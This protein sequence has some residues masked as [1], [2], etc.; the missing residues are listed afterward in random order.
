MASKP[1]E[2]PL[3]IWAPPGSPLRVE[4]SGGVMEEIRARAVNGFYKVRGGVDVAGL[5]LGDVRPD[6]VRILDHL[7]FEI[8]YAHGPAFALSPRDLALVRKLIEEISN[9]GLEASGPDGARRVLG[10]CIS[11][12]RSDLAL[13]AGEIQIFDQLFPHAWQTILLLKPS[14]ATETAAAFFVR[15]PDGGMRTNR[16]YGE[17]GVAPM[18]GERR[19]RPAYQEA[20]SLRALAEAARHGSGVES[21]AQDVPAREP[22]ARESLAQP[23]SPPL[24]PEMSEED[25][26]ARRAVPEKPSASHPEP[27]FRDAAG[28]T[29]STAPDGLADAQPAPPLEPAAIE[30]RD[31]ER[32]ALPRPLAALTVK[33]DALADPETP[34]PATGVPE[35]H[36]EELP[37]GGVRATSWLR[38]AMPS[39]ALILLLVLGYLVYHA[40]NGAPPSVVFFRRAAGDSQEIVWRVQGM[41][42]ARSAVITIKNGDETRT[43]DLIRTGQLSGVYRDSSLTAASAVTMDIER[44]TGEKIHREAPPLDA[45]SVVPYLG[46]FSTPEPEASSTPE[47]PAAAA[48]GESGDPRPILA[49]PVEAD[50][51]PL[52]A[53]PSVPVSPPVASVAS[54]A[55]PVPSV[56]SP[57][58]S[59]GERAAG[60]ATPRLAPESPV[61]TRVTEAPSAA[62]PESLAPSVT[63]P[64]P[65]LDSGSRPPANPPSASNAA[66]VPP[67]HAAA[68]A[69]GNSGAGQVPVSQPPVSPPPVPRPLAPP[70][71][72]VQQPAAAKA[73]P[74][75]V[76]AGRVIWTGQLR[77]NQSLQIDGKAATLGVMSAALP[78]LPVRVNVLPGELTPQGLIVYTA[79]PRYRNVGNAVEPP[80]PTNGWNQTHYRYDP[81]RAQ[82]LIVTG[83]PS[84]A[85]GWRRV[86]V[87]NEDKNTSVIVIDWQADEP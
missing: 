69:A 51:L 80:G 2:S 70:A 59:A 28:D 18:M 86:T 35:W 47:A 8:E 60:G 63:Q 40:L 72:A 26:L 46:G 1:V 7:P 24:Q 71:P 83:P 19:A 6:S 11:H 3:F 42:D 45:D 39:V 56:P 85:N 44:S 34:E 50:P 10:L 5:L 84:E 81:V 9:A 14:H 30:P 36:E 55:P 67:P 52:E 66:N 38:W 43:I 78:G 48:G 76:A 25:I 87:R 22:A 27:P 32:L 61:Q 57:V 17:F 12:A 54:S 64:G 49:T 23:E 74:A 13:S 33:E 37:P 41:G 75:R 20:S 58:E 77:K 68:P 62:R 16:S 31:I 65:A 21:P 79:N 82:S 53:K 73:S 15:E 4:Y 29:S